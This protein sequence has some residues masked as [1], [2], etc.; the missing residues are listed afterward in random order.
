MQPVMLR[1]IQ[2]GTPGLGFPYS[3][4]PVVFYAYSPPTGHTAKHLHLRMH[5]AAYSAQ[6]SCT[7]QHGIYPPMAMQL[8]EP[9]LL[10]PAHCQHP[11][12]IEVHGS[13]M[14]RVCISA[15]C[16]SVMH[17]PVVPRLRYT[18]FQDACRLHNMHAMHVIIFI[19][20]HTDTVPSI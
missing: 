17:E 19:Q 10:L 9:M 12:Q 18:E 20:F 5:D 16:L 2:H 7:C 8:C 4:V 1:N 6:L 14:T 11:A 15:I 3:L 13:C